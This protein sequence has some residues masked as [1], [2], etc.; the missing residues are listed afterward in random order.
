[1]KKYLLSTVA[2]SAVAAVVAWSVPVS[3]D[4]FHGNG[5]GFGGQGDNG[6]HGSSPNEART[7]TP[8]KHLVVIFNENRS[9]DHYFATYPTA[10]NPSGEPVF[11]A[12]RNTPAVNN[13]S[14]NPGLLTNNPNF[15]NT[16]NG[17]GAANPFRLD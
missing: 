7:A 3:A 6:H 4:D 2:M 10:K 16:A 8:I 13:L 5:P 1:M 15:T 11:T 14:A 12:A 9:F 17:T